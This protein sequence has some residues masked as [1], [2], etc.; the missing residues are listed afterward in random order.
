MSKRKEALT[1]VLV[2]FALVLVGAAAFY[3]LWPQLQPHATV[4]I[5][6]GVFK[7]RVATTEEARVQG[8]SGTTKLAED[9]AFLMVFDHE[10]EWSVWMKD[11][12]Y[13]IDIV[14]LSHDKKVVHIVKN[15]PPESYPYEKFTPKKAAKYVLELPAGTVDG[16]SI[17]IDSQA[18]FDETKLEVSL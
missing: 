12:K 4:R 17:I 3:V 18:A 1:W 5:G 14:W 7:T 6:D 9:R 8:L 15:A 10:G 11:M 2:T 13:P 16:K